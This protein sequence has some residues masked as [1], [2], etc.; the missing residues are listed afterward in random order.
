MKR[1]PFPCTIEQ[2]SGGSKVKDAFNRPKEAVRHRFR[3]PRSVNMA[4]SAL[5]GMP[6]ILLI[7][8]LAVLVWTPADARWRH[9]HHYHHGPKTAQ[10][11]SAQQSRMLVPPG[12]QRQTADPNWPVERYL[13]PDGTGSFSAYIT[14]VAQ[15]PIAQHMKTVAFVDGEQITR[16]RGKK[17][18]FEVS[19]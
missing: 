7:S 14:P 17:S 2:I 15:E 16:L 5:S 11:D 13:S 9:H 8:L 6:R 4:D 3:P 19:G 18:W 1:F 12:W 10:H